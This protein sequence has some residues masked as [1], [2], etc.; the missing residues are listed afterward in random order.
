MGNVEDDLTSNSALQKTLEVSKEAATRPNNVPKPAQHAQMLETLEQAR[1]AAAKATRDGEVELQ[2]KT[3]IVAKLK[4][5]LE[6]WD[7]RDPLEEH[8]VDS[9]ACVQRRVLS[10]CLTYS[11]VYVLRFGNQWDL[12]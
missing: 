6:A 8:Q 11:T 1:Y 7:R 9:F 5:D 10:K 3:A 12:S 2:T 4:E